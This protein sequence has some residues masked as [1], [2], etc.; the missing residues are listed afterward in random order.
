MASAQRLPPSLEAPFSRWISCDTWWKGHPSDEER[1][2]RFVWAVARYSRRP[3]S[4][5]ALRELITSEWG[6][7]SEPEF[8][9]EQALR[10]S[11]LYATF[12][13]FAK[14]RRKPEPFLPGQFD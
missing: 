1:F 10:F 3:P 9:R 12:L 7:R 6:G 5:A 4:E 13:E 11:Q 2:Y 14:V 8:L